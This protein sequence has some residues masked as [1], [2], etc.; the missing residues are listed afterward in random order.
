MKQ[1]A[2]ESMDVQSELDALRAHNLKLETDLQASRHELVQYRAWAQAMRGLTEQLN[3]TA[4]QSFGA[5]PPESRKRKEAPSTPYPRVK[6][7]VSRLSTESSDES[8]V[9]DTPIL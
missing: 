3:V 7:S 1:P 4:S 5:T 6:F 2:A 9:A 8:F